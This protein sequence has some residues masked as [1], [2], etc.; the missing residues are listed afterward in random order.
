MTKKKTIDI[1]V[2]FISISLALL[3][4]SPILYAISVSFMEPQ[5]VLSLPPN[6]IP[7]KFTFEN[8]ITA[9][10]R[11]TLLRYMLNSFIVSMLSSFS[12]IVIASFSA[13]AFSFFK[14]KGRNI[15]FALTMATIMIPPNV[16]IVE[17]FTTISKLGLV[18]TYLGISSVFLVSATNIF[19]LRQTFLSFPRTLREAAIIDGCNNFSFFWRILIPLSKP[20]LIMI[21]ISSFINVWNQ[22]VWP[23]LVTN[24][25]EMRTIQ[26]GITMLKDRESSIFGPVMAGVVIALI[27]TIVLFVIFQKK[28]VS[29]MME[30]SVKE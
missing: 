26:V 22:Y 17:N 27:P 1:Y 20:I 7:P 5:D 12:R 18:N 13:Y 14:F 16:L 19:L 6:V 11:T 15:L 24:Q 9:F 30:G 29:G 10:T 2:Q 3:I 21:F 23:L 25:N 4:L 28:I 8:Y